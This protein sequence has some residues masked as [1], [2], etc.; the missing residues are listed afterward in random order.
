MSKL[1]Q[2]QK[3][4]IANFLQV[5]RV[6]FGLGHRNI[7]LRTKLRHFRRTI[8]QCLLIAASVGIGGAA[9]A[10]S[11]C[12]DDVDMRTERTARQSPSTA[13]AWKV[14]SPIE[15]MP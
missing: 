2:R 14:R 8:V 5:S 11:S 4:N 6:H 7:G 10:E 15:R 9:Y 1:N 13:D 12:N 3:T